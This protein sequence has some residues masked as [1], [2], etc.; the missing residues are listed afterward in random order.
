MNIPTLI[1]CAYC[2]YYTYVVYGLFK[3]DKLIEQKQKNLDMDKLRDIPVKTMEEQKQFLDL[4]YPKKKEKF[5][6]TWLWLIKFIGQIILGMVIFIGYGKGFDYFG[7]SF[8]WFWAI[9]GTLGATFVINILLGY[10]HLE[11]SDIKQWLRW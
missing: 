1:V 8:T 5:K 9:I 4:K 6:F 11:Q 2:V 7:I 10:F 3:K